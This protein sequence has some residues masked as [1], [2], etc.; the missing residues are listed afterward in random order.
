MYYSKAQV[1]TIWWFVNV[2][3]D[4]RGTSCHRKGLQLNRADNS[5]F[6]GKSVNT[7]PAKTVDHM[8]QETDVIRP[9][10]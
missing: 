9:V 6:Y 8:G 4:L 1:L 7:P 10:V 2:Y 3:G 5:R